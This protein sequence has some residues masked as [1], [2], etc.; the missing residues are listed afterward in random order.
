MSL[1][2][3]P[4]RQAYISILQRMTPAERL[5][6]AWELTEAVR[7]MTLVGLRRRNPDAGE[8]ELHDLYL[9]CLKKCHNRTY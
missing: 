2:P 9:A 8:D 7:E 6:K 1:K 4:N 3:T 5:K